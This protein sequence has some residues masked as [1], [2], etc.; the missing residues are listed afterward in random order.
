M[1]GVIKTRQAWIGKEEVVEVWFDPKRVSF[2]QLLAHG[3]TKE[4]ARNV[5][6]RHDAHAAAAKEALGDQAAAA[7]KQLRLDKEQKYYLLQTPL[8]A[9][10]LSEAQACRVNASLEGEAFFRYL[11]PRQAKAAATLFVAASKK[12]ARE[13]G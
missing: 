5:W 8:V 12:R 6:W 4:C 10:P 3:R 1:D 2:D 9:L 13:S 11:S 7:P